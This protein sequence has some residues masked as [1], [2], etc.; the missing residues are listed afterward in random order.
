[1]LTLKLTLTLTLTLIIVLTVRRSDHLVHGDSAEGSLPGEAHAVVNAHPELKLPRVLAATDT[2]SSDSSPAIIIIIITIII[3]RSKHTGNTANSPHH[4][5]V[6]ITIRIVYIYI[7][8][9]IC[10][11][12][13]THV[14]NII[15]YIYI[16]IHRDRERLL[17]C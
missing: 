9:Y 1:M 6:N 10:I 3:P 7:Y 2:N 16:C 11:H 5:G 17:N 15:V 14:N 8:I 4:K 12:I 13:C